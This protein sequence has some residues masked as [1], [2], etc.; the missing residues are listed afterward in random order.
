MIRGWSGSSVDS[1]EIT[2]AGRRKEVY[3]EAGGTEFKEWRLQPDEL[4]IAVTQERQ[5]DGYLGYAFVFFTSKGRCIAI[6]GSLAANKRRFVAPAR[7]QITG[8]MFEDSSLTGIM[9][10]K[11]KRPHSTRD[12]ID[13]LVASIS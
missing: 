2:Y 11:A 10:E 7:T 8:L 1:V 9:I 12:E 6:L 4:I 13:G 3:G 5:G